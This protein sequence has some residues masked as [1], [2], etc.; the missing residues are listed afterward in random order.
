[1]ASFGAYSERSAI[2]QWWELIL[3]RHSVLNYRQPLQIPL[4]HQRTDFTSRELYDTA[5]LT[6]RHTAGVRDQM[7][8]RLYPRQNPR[9]IVG[10]GRWTIFLHE[11]RTPSGKLRL[12]LFESDIM[13]DD[14]G[15]TILGTVQLLDPGTLLHPSFTF[16]PVQPAS[17]LRF[18]ASIPSERRLYFTL[19]QVKWGRDFQ[20]FPARPDPADASA[21]LLDVRVD[22]KT[23]TL[24]GRIGDDDSFSISTSDGTSPPLEIKP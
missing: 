2:S 21:F 11:R 7:E 13:W 17:G 23:K 16:L 3:L 22:G 20:L 8:G 24:M 4:F 14:D 1:V 12:V 9:Q 5:S 15:S 18:A 6:M 19:A 10:P